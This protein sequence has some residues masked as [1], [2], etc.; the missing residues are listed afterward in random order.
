[1]PVRGAFAGGPS[2]VTTD[3]GLGEIELT[4]AEI[5]ERMSGN[6]YRG[7]DYPNMLIITMGGDVPAA[8]SNGAS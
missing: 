1:M 5:R 4:K 2:H 7:A 3:V 8:L 6:I